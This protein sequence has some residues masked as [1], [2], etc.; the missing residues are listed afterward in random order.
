MAAEVDV[1][2]LLVVLP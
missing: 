2:F 1:Q